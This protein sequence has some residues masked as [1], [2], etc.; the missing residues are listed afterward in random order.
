VIENVRPKLT[1]GKRK[2]I[3]ESFKDV[4]QFKET[5]EGEIKE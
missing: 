3:D 5:E 1:T 4:A 2:I